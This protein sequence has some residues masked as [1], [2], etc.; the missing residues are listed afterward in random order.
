MQYNLADLWETGRRHGSRPGGARLRRPPAHLRRGRRARNRLAHYLAAQGIGP[1]DHVALYLYNGTEYLEAMLAAFKLRA[2]P[3]N[4]NYRY[5]EDELRYLLDDSDAKA[6]VFH[7]EF[8]PKL[9]AMRDRAPAARHVRRSRRRIRRR[10][11]RARRP[12][13]TRR[14]SPPRRPSA[15]SRRAPPTT[16]TSSTRAAPPACPRA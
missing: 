10:A 6:V 11:R 16:S 7:R 12:S 1:G 4:V 2:V 3:V 9:D 5:V 13:T 15:T 14:R 8:A